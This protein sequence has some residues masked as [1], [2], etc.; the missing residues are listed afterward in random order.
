M[1]WFQFIEKKYGTKADIELA[2][3]ENCMTFFESSF[4]LQIFILVGGGLFLFFYTGHTPILIVAAVLLLIRL[5]VWFWH[6][7]AVGD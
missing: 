5:V 6:K 2:G 7:K 4:R 1:S 3:T